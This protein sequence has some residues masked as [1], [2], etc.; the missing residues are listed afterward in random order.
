MR[1]FLFF[2]ICFYFI[3]FIFFQ[4]KTKKKKINPSS[5]WHSKWMMIILFT[6]WSAVLK[7][8]P[9]FIWNII[10]HIRFLL[11]F[12][13]FYEQ[14]NKKYIYYRMKMACCRILLFERVQEF[15]DFKV[16]LKLTVM[17]CIYLALSWLNFMYVDAQVYLI[18]TQTDIH[19]LRSRT[20]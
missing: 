20:K 11:I 4:I 6:F 18:R 16:S 2:L 7:F 10:A 17:M 5:K 9:R 19:R 12:A 13:W 15:C 1:V 8:I 14:Q 3:E